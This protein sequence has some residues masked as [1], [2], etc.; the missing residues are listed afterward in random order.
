MPCIANHLRKN[1][2]L[3]M[4][5]QTLVSTFVAK[6]KADVQDYYEE[7]TFRKER[8]IKRRKGPPSSVASTTPESAKVPPK[9]VKKT[10]KTKRVIPLEKKK[11]RVLGEESPDEEEQ[12]EAEEEDLF[13][14]DSQEESNDDSDLFSGRFSS[15]AMSGGGRDVVSSSSSKGGQFDQTLQTM[16]QQAMTCGALAR[17]TCL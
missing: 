12:E 4:K 14:E 10:D 3:P 17:V 6:A 8:D 1:G 11:T 7:V 9:D 15:P 13:G 16:I 2:D 5:L